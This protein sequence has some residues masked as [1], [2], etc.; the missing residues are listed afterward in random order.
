LR[1]VARSGERASTMSTL[2]RA[3]ARDKVRVRARDKVRVRVG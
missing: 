2:V 1:S 3:R